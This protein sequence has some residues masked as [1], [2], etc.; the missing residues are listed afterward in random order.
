M[1]P[2]PSLLPNANAGTRRSGDPN[3][4]ADGPPPR[5]SGAS[6]ALANALVPAVAEVTINRRLIINKALAQTSQGSGPKVLKTG[7]LPPYAWSFGWAALGFKLSYMSLSAA[8]NRPDAG[9]G[10]QVLSGGAAGAVS[11]VV[12]TLF[13]NVAF[14]Q[15]R[16]PALTTSKAVCQVLRLRSL[17]GLPANAARDALWGGAIT[18]GR[19]INPAVIAW[20][21]ALADHDVLAAA[22][23]SVATSVPVAIA[24][25]PIDLV[26]TIQ[27]QTPPGQKPQSAAEI[28]KQAVG[29]TGRFA[30]V[31]GAS[32]VWTGLW[33]RVTR[34]ATGAVVINVTLNVLAALKGSGARQPTNR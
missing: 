17:P 21:P 19:A 14:Q 27:A 13:T 11:S 10:R 16:N 33:P 32:P 34:I 9:I 4:A 7:A 8:G 1:Y 15:Q 29:R 5:R 3:V 24:N 25:H 6:W 28:L 22:V 18:C 26:A 20:V 2:P 30:G 31:T 23:G 12:A